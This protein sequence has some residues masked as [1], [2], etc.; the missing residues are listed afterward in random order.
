MKSQNNKEQESDFSYKE[1]LN[2]L[3]TDFSMRA[4]SVLREPE[5]QDFWA[6]NDIDFQLGSSNSGEIFTLHDG[7]PYANGALHMGH[8]LNKVLKDV[9]NKYKTLRG[10]RVHFVPGWDC[11]G[12]PIELKVLQNLKSDE[13]KNLDALNLRKKATDYAYVQINNQMQGFKR[14]GI[15]GDW[16]NPYLTLRK[17]TNLLRLEYL[18]KCF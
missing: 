1:T 6:K 2:L 7:P 13:R 17:V 10:F 4:N 12:L 5:I 8:A 11:H 9:I 18:G 14:W 16:D 3:K 15:W